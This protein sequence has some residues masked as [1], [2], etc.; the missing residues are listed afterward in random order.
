M[1]LIYTVLVDVLAPPD[2][3]PS[4]VTVLKT[5]LDI[6]LSG[7]H[8]CRPH[9]C[10]KKLEFRGAALL[11][12]FRFSYMY[13]RD[14]SSPSLNTHDGVINWKHFPHCWPVVRG[15]H[16]SPVVSPCKGW[17]SVCFFAVLYYYL[18]Y[19]SCLVSCIKTIAVLRSY[20]SIMTA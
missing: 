5:P 7:F 16:R 12:M 13:K 1:Y 9:N 10:P 8:K 20:I 17:K 14:C 2:A 19:S 11:S 6:A 3:R 4:T 15:G 18:S